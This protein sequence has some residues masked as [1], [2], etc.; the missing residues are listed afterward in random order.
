MGLGVPD[1]SRSD[2]ARLE[3]I[4]R[5][6]WL[7]MYAAAPPAFVQGVGLSAARIGSG[8][9]FA[10]RAVPLIQ[11]N[12][13]HALGLDR[14]IDGLTID[15]AIRALKSKAS[16][17]WALQL[18]DLLEFAAAASQ[19]RARGLSANSGWAKFSRPAQSPPPE[20]TSLKIEEVGRE[21]AGDFGSVVQAAFGAPP[22]FAS[23]AAAVVGRPGWRAF[24]G[25]DGREPVAA[26]ALFL[27]GG[28]GWLG[29]GATIPSHRGRGA[30]GALLSR[31]IVA[32]L[33]AGAH[34]VVTETGRPEPGEETKHP[35]YRNILRAGFQ[36]VYLRMNYRPSGG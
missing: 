26:G 17:V 13:A 11:F 27:S 18:P 30:Q 4:E 23:W 32:A 35:S 9:V 1:S 25:Y 22:P 10:I 16:P 31:R 6:A 14:P 8:A 33:E 29:L 19:L 36:E 3:A 24:V 7:D 28:F 12:H 5:D 21:R 20:K 34:T 15:E 2:V